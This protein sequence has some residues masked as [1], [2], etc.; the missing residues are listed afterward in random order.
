MDELAAIAANQAYL[1]SRAHQ[2][3]PEG[4]TGTYDATF[5]TSF[6]SQFLN[7]RV[8]FGLAEQEN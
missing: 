6:T 5:S 4:P 3:S 1:D 8:S 2:A 7:E